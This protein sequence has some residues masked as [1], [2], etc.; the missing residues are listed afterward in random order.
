MKI[1]LPLLLAASALVTSFCLTGYFRRY[2]L[3]RRIL[4]VP[5]PRSSHTVATPRGGGLA[6]VLATLTVLTGGALTGALDWSRI[7]GVLVGGAVVAAVGFADDRYHMPRLW[8]FLAH[9]G[10]AA[11]VLASAGGFPDLSLLG[12]PVAFGWAGQLL[13][14]LYVVWLLNLTNFM[15]GI[16][17]IA[18]TEATMVAG[19]GALLYV[20]GDVAASQFLPP[21]AVAA[22]SLGFLA[23]NWPPAKIFMGDAGSGFL[24]LLLAALSIDAAH[25]TR[26]LFWSWMILMGVFVT[27]ATLTLARRTARGERPYEAHRMHAYQHAAR[28]YGSHK[29]VTVAVAGINLLWLLPLATLV[30]RGVLDGAVATLIAYAPLVLLAAQLGAG[31]PYPDEEGLVA[32]QV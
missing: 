4:D 1:A 12:R 5:N 28:R 9:V 21:L 20:L 30:A 14:L 7:W 17:G 31:R 23:W 13:A 3:A 10:A 26:P 16:D 22:A 25:A 2:A 27:D 8:R 6:I 15:D 11:C 32:S 24:G 19:G 18:A 29:T